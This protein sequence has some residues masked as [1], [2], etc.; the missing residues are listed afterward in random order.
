MAILVYGFP[1]KVSALKF[2]WVWQKPGQ[3]RHFREL[4][5]NHP[6][7]SREST[8]QGKLEGRVKVLLT[9]LNL[10]AWKR[11]PLCVCIPDLEVMQI[12]RTY[13]TTMGTPEEDEEDERIHHACIQDLPFAFADQGRAYGM[14]IKATAATEGKDNPGLWYPYAHRLITHHSCSQRSIRHRGR[15]G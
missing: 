1:S 5:G 13:Q 3:S 10:P 6:S 2:E 12:L 9:M 8:A 4:P 11:L 14:W 15:P 7:N